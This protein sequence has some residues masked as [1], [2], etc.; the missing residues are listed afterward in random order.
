MI[1]VVIVGST[2]GLI[3]IVST[4]Y[5]GERRR[6]RLLRGTC[7]GLFV[8]TLCLGLEPAGD[9]VGLDLV[10]RWSIL[11][12]QASVSLLVLSFRSGRG[13][14]LASRAVCIVSAAIALAEAV[15]AGFLPVHGDGAVYRQDEVQRLL[16]HDQGWALVAYQGLYLTAFGAATAVV[17]AGCTLTV[18][19]RNQPFA[20]RLPVLFVLAGAIG[21]A[22]Y[23]ASSLGDLVGHPVLGGAENRTYLLIAVVSLFFIG[24][25]LGII[26]GVV[27]SMRRSL[28]LRM[29]RDVVLPLW[30]TTTR[31]HP[32]VMLPTEDREEFDDLLELSRITIETH[33]A[34][35]FIREDDDPALLHLHRLHPEEPQLSA[36]LLRHLSGER[37]VPR[38]GWFTVVLTRLRAL[39]LDDEALGA[40]I[41]S[42]YEIRLAMGAMR[43]QEA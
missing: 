21:S 35:R 28:A 26:R 13:A 39:R 7:L 2:M 38:L 36:G 15:L 34:L 6:V 37:S 5:R 16:A 11:S 17:A 42:L 30:R 10:K 19:Q 1:V 31:L 14:R 40:S 8:A 9:G 29:A 4:L 20:A 32:D 18:L 12:A 24:L 43:S 41:R 25:S 27:M 23:I 33:D 3:V 22:L